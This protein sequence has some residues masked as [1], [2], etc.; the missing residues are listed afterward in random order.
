MTNNN[1]ATSVNFNMI[2]RNKIL[3][4]G[5]CFLFSPKLD[6]D[7]LTWALQLVEIFE[8]CGLN[9]AYSVH[10]FIYL[11]IYLFWLISTN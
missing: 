6:S 4:V 11:S 3:K 1:C 7:I 8:F 10:L 9:L 5:N 2:Y